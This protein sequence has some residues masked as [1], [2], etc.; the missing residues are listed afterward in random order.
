MGLGNRSGSFGLAIFA[1]LLSVGCGTEEEEGFS[2]GTE[3]LRA[4]VEGTYVGTVQSTGAAVSITLTYRPPA[5]T[6]ATS[7]RR[8]AC[9]SRTLCIDTTT[10]FLDATV[11]GEGVSALPHPTSA[12]VEVDG[13]DFSRGS[14]VLTGAD[15]WL[16][17][18]CGPEQMA[19]D[20]TYYREGDTE[21]TLALTPVK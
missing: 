14:I 6:G 16:R 13:I 10:M 12:W 9:G 3:E 4:A 19:H 18:S 20:W 5:T 1:L 8:V 21:R 15:G 17:A 2:F 7:L 11:E